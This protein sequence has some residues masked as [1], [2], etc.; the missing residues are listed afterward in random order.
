MSMTMTAILIIGVHSIGSTRIVK[1][2]QAQ[3]IFQFVSGARHDSRF[4]AV[5]NYGQRRQEIWTFSAVIQGLAS[6]GF[7][8]E[9]IWTTTS[10]VDGP[11]TVKKLYRL[12]APFEKTR[13]LYIRVMRAELK[14]PLLGLFQ[15]DM[16]QSLSIDSF[17]RPSPLAPETKTIHVSR[18]EVFN[19]IANAYC[20]RC[21]LSSKGAVQN[22]WRSGRLEKAR[23]RAREGLWKVPQDLL[24]AALKGDEIKR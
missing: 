1:L 9:F 5:T 14:S 16:D 20:Y 18:K 10:V 7:M 24:S 19:T 11:E 22:E 8:L 4:N 15:I 12:D 13:R 21:V 23:C 3:A 6:F 2:G 17:T